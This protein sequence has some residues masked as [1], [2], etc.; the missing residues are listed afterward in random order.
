MKTV[1]MSQEKHDQL[2]VEIERLKNENQMLKKQN[3]ELQVALDAYDR[4][5][6][7]W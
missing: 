1:V 4:E 6:I 7:S 5:H 2:I 3:D